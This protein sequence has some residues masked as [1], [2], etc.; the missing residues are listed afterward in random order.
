MELELRVQRWHDWI[1]AFSFTLTLSVCKNVGSRTTFEPAIAPTPHEAH[2]GDK[3]PS[4]VVG[5]QISG[6]LGT[7]S[8]RCR[9]R[10]PHGRWK[11]EIEGRSVA[12]DQEL[13]NALGK[14]KTQNQKCKVVWHA[15]MASMS[16]M[17]EKRKGVETS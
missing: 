15:N 5:T 16:V 8:Q 2:T 3:A 10:H 14:M 13:Q 9:H 11:R 17:V 12:N 7:W 6:W 4:N 1:V